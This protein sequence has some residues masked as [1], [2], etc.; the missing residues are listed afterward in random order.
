MNGHLLIID[1]ED[2]YR[3]DTARLVRKRGLTC[4]TAPDG[5][6]GLRLAEERRPDVILCDLM[7]PGISGI[8]VLD[9]LGGVCPEAIVFVVTAHATIETAIEAL[10]RGAHDYLLKPV[11]FEDLLAK[12]SRA[13]EVR[14]LR[15][16][17]RTLRREISRPEETFGIVGQNPRIR[18]IL[19]LITR[20]PRNRPAVI[21]RGETGT[22]KELVARAVHLVGDPPGKRFVALNCAAIPDHLIESE[23]FGYRKGAFTG[24]IEDREG[25]FERAHGGTLFLDEVAAMPLS[26]QAKLLRA[27]EQKEIMPIGARDPVP[28]DARI[29]ASAQRDLRDLVK[30]GTFRQDLFYRLLVV[31]I[32]LP[33]LRE[34]RD[35]I[36]LILEH[37]V[38]RLTAEMKVGC[39]GVEPDALR[40]LMAYS[41]PGNI[42]ELRN[43]VERALIVLK[44]KVLRR[45]DFPRDIVAGAEEA[46]GHDELRLAVRA[47]EREHIRQVLAECGGHRERAASR[48]GIDRAT[49]YRKIKDL[50]VP[51]L[52]AAE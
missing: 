16:E 17:V 18:E 10:R 15:R 47:Y 28:A 50:G 2:S 8:E 41:W 52:D 26:L 25:H 24:A 35:D 5:T 9:R 3:E 23:L 42:R 6:T 7:M 1:D 12:I 33:P 46:V 49:L 14:D 39:E 51:G 36:P 40:A 20:L 11:L 38:R 45:E 31:E 37:Y 21:V 4:T 22:G 32:V 34:R 27:I 19:D 13:L 29:V 30:E 44:G 48:L 43:A